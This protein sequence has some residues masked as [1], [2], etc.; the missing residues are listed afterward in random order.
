MPAVKK[1]TEVL[2]EKTGRAEPA[3]SKE[4]ILG[5]ARYREQKDLADALLDAGRMY[6][7]KT[8]D[9]MIENYM[10]RKVE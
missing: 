3:F 4:Q 2:E 1:K 6:T 7:F 5:S 9:S 8:V 10:K